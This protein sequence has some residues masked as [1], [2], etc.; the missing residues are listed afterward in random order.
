MDYA[1]LFAKFPVDICGELA[2]LWIKLLEPKVDYSGQKSPWFPE[3]LTLM[4]PQRMLKQEVTSYGSQYAAQDAATQIIGVDPK[5]SGVVFDLTFDFAVE[6]KT[7][8][9]GGGSLHAATTP[10]ALHNGQIVPREGMIPSVLQTPLVGQEVQKDN[11]IGILKI[12]VANE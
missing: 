8:S 3:D 2:D 11:R 7:Y 4:K 5:S 9:S 6:W 1:E 10:C 12:V